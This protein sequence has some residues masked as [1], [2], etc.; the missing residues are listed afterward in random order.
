MMPTLKLA[1][2]PDRVPVKLT[3]QI[4]PELYQALGD[5]VAIYTETYAEAAKIED[6]VPAMLVHFL[7]SDRGFRKSA[8]QARR[9]RS[10][11]ER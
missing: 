9:E 11:N 4:V 8:D 6:I 3:L 2:L 7:Q 1:R 10:S 5:Y